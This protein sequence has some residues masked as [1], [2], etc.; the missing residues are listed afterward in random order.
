MLA[1]AIA[2]HLL[3]NFWPDLFG[4]DQETD[5]SVI[6]AT[7]INGK[8]ILGG[9]SHYR[10]YAIVDRVGADALRT[11]LIKHRPE[12]MKTD[13]VGRKPNDA[14]YHAETTVLLRATRANGGTLAGQDLEVVVDGP[15]CPSC[16]K[17]LPYVGLELGNPRV[18]FID[19][20]GARQT[21]HNGKWEDAETSP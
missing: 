21:I 18:T 14:I 3:K 6:A 19:N 11:D 7:T 10:D 15:M 8:V 13:N 20:T 2:E 9:N 4:N 17:V 16:R 1:N 5:D 12:I